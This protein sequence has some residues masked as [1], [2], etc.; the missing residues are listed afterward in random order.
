MAMTGGYPAESDIDTYLSVRGLELIPEYDANFIP[1]YKQAIWG[2]LNAL[3]WATALGVYC[4]STTTFNVRG[5]KYLFK[6]V[7]KTYTAG[8]AVNPT[9]NDTTYIWMK[10]DNTIS[11]AID[12]TGWPST[13][14]IKL[15]EI[16]VNSSGVITAVRDLRGQTFL[17]YDSKKAIEAH[18][19]NDTLTEGESDS[20]HTNLGAGGTITLT[21]PASAPQGTVF[22]FAVQAAQELR[23][24]PGTATIRDDSGQTA[25]KYKTAN[26][27][28]ECLTL[29][30]DSN[31]DWATIAKHGTWTEEA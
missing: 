24:D 6:G 1:E 30:A 21:L 8:S 15:A 20:V 4:P 3:D 18:T 25:D 27:I 13:E 29:I 23:V 2:L 22:T 16:D 5:G 19:A 12:G 10:P 28:G 7:V 14:H 26:A 11:S 9:D 31:G 17:N